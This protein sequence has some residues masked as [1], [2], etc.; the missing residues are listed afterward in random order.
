MQPSNTNQNNQPSQPPRIQDT[1]IPDYLHL[2]Y[3]S[4]LP[5]WCS[6]YS[7]HE[8]F[9]EFGNIGYLEL[10][11]QKGMNPANGFAI[12][13]FISAQSVQQIMRLYD[14]G[15]LRMDGTARASTRSPSSAK[16]TFSSTSR[17]SGTGGSTSRDFRSA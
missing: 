12:V 15:E 9:R 7:L 11:I 8:F 6:K 16:R 17:T 13:G 10:N 1:A 4:S 5:K 14:S 3:V 2:L